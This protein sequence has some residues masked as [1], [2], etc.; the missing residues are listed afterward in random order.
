MRGIYLVPNHGTMILEGK[1]KMIVKSKPF[2]ILG[3]TFILVERDNALGEITIKE[4]KEFPIE[5]FYKMNDLHRISEV[6]RKKWWPDAKTF[7]SYS[8]SFKP[9][10]EPRKVVLKKGIQTFI[11]SV[12]FLDEYIKNFLT[13]DPSTLSDKILSD[14]FRIFCAWYS[15]LKSGKSIL[16]GEEKTPLT[17][18]MLLE[19]A[20]LIYK[21]I[22]KRVGEG[23]MTYQFRPDRMAP[24][25]KEL[26]YKVKMMD[27][28]KEGFSKLTPLSTIN[29]SGLGGTGREIKIE[30][31]L[32]GLESFKTRDPSI[33][34]VGGLANYGRTNGDIDILIRQH[35][36][37]PVPNVPL[38]FRIYRQFPKEMWGR[39]HFIYDES[40]G[41]FTNFVPLYDQAYLAKK[42]F[43]VVLMQGEEKT[44]EMMLLKDGSKTR[45][46]FYFPK[47]KDDRVP[48]LRVSYIGGKGAILYSLL[49]KIP[50]D[51][52]SI[53]DPMSG[54]GAFLYA[55]KNSGYSV[56][57]NDILYSCSSI[58]DG[59]IANDSETLTDE[60][61]MGILDA[62]ERKG[63][64]YNY[65]TEQ[66]LGSFP[67]K[68]RAVIDGMV[69]ES[70]KLSPIKKKI[71]NASLFATFSRISSHNTSWSAANVK[72]PKSISQFKE[73]LL[74]KM[75]Y[76]NMMIEANRK[77]KFLSSGNEDLNEFLRH[78]KAD[79]IYLD[80]PYVT[81]SSTSSRY[82]PLFLVDNVILQRERKIPKCAFWNSS[83]IK[84]KMEEMI[85]A[86]KNARYVMLSY[87]DNELFSRNRISSVLK[88][89]FKNVRLWSV[90]VYYSMRP[91]KFKKV[92]ER[93]LI[94]LATNEKKI[95]F[96]RVKGDVVKMAEESK[97]EDKIKPFRFF[98]QAKPMHARKP[99]EEYSYE[100]VLRTLNEQDPDWKK[101]TIFVGRKADGVT[102]QASK[103]KNKVVVWIE[104]GGEITE[105]IP[106]IV[107][108]LSKFKN[109]FVIIGE[110]EHWDNDKHS[111]RAV[112]NG[113]LHSKEV[114][115]E[116]K[117]C[118]LAVYDTFWVNGK[119]I[120][121]KDYSY[122][123]EI[124]RK[125]FALTKGNIWINPNTLVKN[126]EELKAALNVF[127]KEKGSEGAIINDATG[128]YNIDL[129]PSGM[130]LKYKNEYVLTAKVIG[131]HK[132]K[133]APNTFFYYCSIKDEKGRDVFAGRTFNTNIAAKVGDNIK[134][135]F[136]DISRYYD[137]KKKV[138]WYN[139]WS[140]RVKEITKDKISE[141]KEA[142]TLV[143]KTTGR[144]EEKALPKYEEIE[145]SIEGIYQKAPVLENT[146][147]DPFLI[148]PPYEKRKDLKFA[149]TYHVRGRS[150][151]LD[152]RKE[153]KD[154]LLIG[155]TNFIPKGLSRDPK[156]LNDC[157]KLLKEEIEPLVLETIKDPNKKFLSA[158]KKVEPE[159][160]LG[161][162]GSFPP[163]TV[164]ATKKEWG[165]M[166]TFD[167]GTYE[168]LSMKPYFH[169]YQY[170]GKK[171]NGKFVDRKIENRKEWKKTGE[172]VM[173]WMSFYTTSPPYIVTKRAVEKKFMVPYPWSGLP[174]LA[175][176]KIPKE[177][178]FWNEKDTKKRIELRDGL[179]KDIKE[180]KIELSKTFP[181]V[182]QKHWW[183]DEKGNVSSQHCD[184]RVDFGK[185]EIL[186]F[187]F[188]KCPAVSEEKTFSVYLKPCKDASSM[189]VGLSDAWK[190]PVNTP[191]NPTSNPEC[192]VKT[193]R[194][195]NVKVLREDE[196]EMIFK[197]ENADLPF[198]K[199][200]KITGDEWKWE[201]SLSEF[202]KNELQKIGESLNSFLFRMTCKGQFVIRAGPSKELFYL[203]IGDDVWETDLNPLRN[204]SLSAYERKDFPKKLLDSKKGE[205]LDVEVG[206]PLN[207]SKERPC[208]IEKTD[209]GKAQILQWDEDFKKFILNVGRLKGLWILKREE[210]KSEIWI[211]ERSEMPRPKEE[212]FSKEHSEFLDVKGILF[213]PGTF[214]GSSGKTINLS[215]DVLKNSVLLPKPNT[216]LCYVN[217][218]HQKEEINKAGIMK[219]IYW[220]PEIEYDVQNQKKK[221]ALIYE[222][223][224]TNPTAISYIKTLTVYQ[225]S[226]EIAYQTE[227]DDDNNVVQLYVNGVAL[228]TTPAVE[229]AR[230]ISA[231]DQDTC[232]KIPEVK[233]ETKNI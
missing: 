218:Y 118:K 30:E 79:L 51:V 161:L 192:Y 212:K 53:I 90:P 144:F 121:R 24:T 54:S 217:F 65:K 40:S 201:K 159:E 106:S 174:I 172:G 87:K 188:P 210:P 225:N 82:T 89:H 88:K 137:P 74:N 130:F 62:K 200:R 134:V 112:T 37:E 85:K 165:Y 206:T 213:T 25:S 98:L 73:L 97:A 151:H 104:D 71:F 125:I 15:S 120:H 227:T 77:G 59:I 83:N 193:I 96:Q 18:S 58:I 203:N 117:N 45:E 154:N 228:T 20:L 126:E 12:K 108:Q 2:K 122:R 128:K 115:P 22:M 164:G 177:F 166:V 44:D 207:P 146:F 226:G 131:I 70:R 143:K 205:T 36:S 127:S 33:F 162:E 190:A 113:I 202:E 156:D 111:P 204:T 109:D 46:H 167:E 173:S 220:D 194:R 31:V 124:F 129:K 158:I 132:V 107:N 142:D 3:E 23:T 26:Y 147:Q 19:K 155:V 168:P 140:P 105:N 119:D 219:R 57:G 181:Y 189:R 171:M 215:E 221:G 184:F 1:K 110:I 67:P 185:S 149:V 123:R 93:E 139:W 216:N 229:T 103:V 4:M 163:D 230:V 99:E 209:E 52:K 198:W 84:E 50:K 29:P 38:E 170:H 232:F 80:P 41:P 178:R 86:S 17:E 176:E 56:S 94:F 6:E 114:S 180:K 91:G 28:R 55:A 116:E 135:I 100:T 75:K 157:R 64:F 35:K 32:N 186:H 133:D 60:E 169:E 14:D 27:E 183:L 68:L 95:E 197:V 160:W 224:I 136:V 49:E 69:M 43:R 208:W 191:W 145:I 7:Y 138:F 141:T 222:S 5:D 42:P 233:K 196:K 81:E 39:F 101:N 195:G 214:T 199:F 211:L 152:G 153:W 72:R 76:V 34:L 8:F 66:D 182:I 187:I 150:V 175:E 148:Y 16:V 48:V 13:Y 63:F 47:V 179:Y 61:M 223:T 21:E 11:A 231:C 9:Y 10:D 92:S 78:H 102:I